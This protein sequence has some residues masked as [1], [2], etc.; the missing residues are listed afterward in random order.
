MTNEQES[1]DDRAVTVFDD[2]GTA[3][4]IEDVLRLTL[5]VDDFSC[6]FSAD[7]FVTHRKQVN[8]S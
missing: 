5:I 4:E 8:L 3:L 1:L 7:D 6:T 2:D